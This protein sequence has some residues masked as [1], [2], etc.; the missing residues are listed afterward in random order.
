MAAR[1]RTESVVPAVALVPGRD[2]RVYLHLQHLQPAPADRQ[3]QQQPLEVAGLPHQLGLHRLHHSGHPGPV[4]RPML[5][6]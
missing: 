2:V 3:Q 1:Y 5:L 6:D 4:D